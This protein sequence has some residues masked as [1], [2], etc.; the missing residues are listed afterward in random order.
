MTE[1]EA[2][3]QLQHGDIRGL[4]YLMA[5][6]QVKAVRT[7]FLIT[8]DV[9]LAEDV[10]QDTFMRIH[11]HIRSYDESRPFEP[12]LMRSITNAAL[13]TVEKSSGW[14]Q[15]EP[16]EETVKVDHLLAKAASVEDQVEFALVKAEILAAVWQLSPRQ[17]AVV[18]QRYYLDMSEQEMAETLGSPPGTVKWLL[19]AARGRLR[20]LLGSIRRAQ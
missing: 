20:G 14:V 15:L 2:I 1:A 17:R 10:V 9:Q 3:R 7:A 8:H 6:Y 5:C 19:N 18:V 16:G 4:E 13:N 11:E 12:Y